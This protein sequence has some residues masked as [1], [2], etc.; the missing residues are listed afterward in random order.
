MNHQK[1]I[2]ITSLVTTKGIQL[3]LNIDSAD[4]YDSILLLKLINKCA[5]YCKTKEYKN[6]ISN[7]QYL[8]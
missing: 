2:K 4:K 6:N 1:G 5:I 3:S 8:L 7:E